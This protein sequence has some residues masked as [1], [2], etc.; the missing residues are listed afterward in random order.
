MKLKEKVSSYK[1]FENKFD[2]LVLKVIIF[3]T[4]SF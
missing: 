4:D 3:K 2:T 1:G